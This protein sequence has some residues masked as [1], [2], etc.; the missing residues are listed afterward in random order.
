MGQLTDWSGNARHGTASGAARPF[1][2]T[3]KI[4]TSL[5]VAR[6]DGGQ[7]FDFPSMAALTAGHFFIVIK[8]LNESSFDAGTNNGPWMMSGSGNETYFAWADTGQIV[9][10][11]GQSSGDRRFSYSGS[12]TDWR[13]YERQSSSGNNKAY[14][15]GA[16]V[17]SSGTNTAGWNANP[18]LGTTY[19]GRAAS[20]WVVE[21]VICSSIQDL[22][23]RN[24][25]RDYVN[26][27]YGLSVA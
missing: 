17:F 23:A 3:N 9:D 12:L 20:F 16:S 26:D 24:A 7:A 15:D 6:F 8:M 22:T 5:P 4:N 10:P 1:Y 13:A 18:K 11:W 25:W 2:D 27:K 14:L 19:N 21:M